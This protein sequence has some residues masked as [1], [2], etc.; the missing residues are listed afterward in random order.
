MANGISKEFALYTVKA[1]ISARVMSLD[2]PDDKKR[3]IME[4]FSLPYNP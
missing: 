2:I 3:V 4:R 1:G